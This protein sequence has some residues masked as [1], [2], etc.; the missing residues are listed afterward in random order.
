MTKKQKTLIGIGA[1]AILGYFLWKRKKNRDE[2][3]S[4]QVAELSCAEKKAKWQTLSN[5]VNSPS[6]KKMPID[7]QTLKTQELS[8]AYKSLC[9]G[10]PTKSFTADEATFFDDAYHS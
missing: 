3:K 9:S 6:F 2:E 4:S 1:V 8:I 10:T 5:L 7:Q